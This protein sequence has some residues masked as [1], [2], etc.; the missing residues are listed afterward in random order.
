MV[1]GFIQAQYVNAVILSSILALPALTI[2]SVPSKFSDAL[3]LPFLPSYRAAVPSVGVVQ[4]PM[5]VFPPPLPLQ[6]PVWP[7]PEAS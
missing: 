5:T 2:S 6:V 4:E 1:V 7:F 3:Y